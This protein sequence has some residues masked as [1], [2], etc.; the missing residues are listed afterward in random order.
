MSSTVLLT[1]ATGIV[2]QRLTRSL[3]DAGHRVAVLV[4]G[5]LAETAQMRAEQA[6]MGVLTP[7]QRERVDVVTG[8]MRSPGCGVSGYD[9]DRLRGTV[10]TVWH[11]AADT[12]FDPRLRDEIWLA[13]VFGTRMVMDLAEALG[14][15]RFAYI[16][17]AFVF[18]DYE[19]PAIEVPHPEVATQFSNIYEHS[20]HTAEQTVTNGTLD[21]VI[22]RPPVVV[23]DART[24]EVS[25]FTGYYGFLRELFRLRQSLTSH[26]DPAALRRLGADFDGSTLRLDIGVP[27]LPEAPF[28]ASSVDFVC[29]AMVALS[30][31]P[32]AWG[33]VFHL[34]PEASRSNRFW[35]EQSLLRLGIEGVNFIAPEHYPEYLAGRGADRSLLERRVA[36]SFRPYLPYVSNRNTFAPDNL[37]ALLPNLR[38]VDVDEALVRRLLDYAVGANFGLD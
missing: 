24:G 19:G 35:L 11:C 36:S 7:E 2:G 30:A 3:L 22:F 33:K 38:H 37:R 28:T 34:V 16:S 23:G 29:E 4:R 14:A 1:G 12:R 18:G 32:A 25:G 26:L 8:D 27:A 5:T 21:W 15:R 6:V 9:R 31:L 17:T 20:K 10:D 13:N